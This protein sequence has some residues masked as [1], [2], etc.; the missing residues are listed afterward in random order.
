M[1]VTNYAGLDYGLGRS[2]IDLETGI[3]YGVIS[4]NTVGQAWWDWA[5]AEYGDPHCPKCGNEIKSSDDE[6]LFKCVCVADNGTAVLVHADNCPANELLDDDMP[7]WFDRQEYTCV[8]CKTCYFSEDCFPDEAQGYSFEDAEYTLTDC[9]DSDIFVLKSPYYTFA[10]FCSPY[11]PGAGNLNSPMDGENG[12]KAYALGHEW[13][14]DDKAPYRLF[15]VSDG[16][17]VM[18]ELS[19]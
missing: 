4:Q 8:N 15:R 16:L 5:E 11:V 14:E 18:P 3:R 17:E 1:S 9:L 2:N 12:A 10:Q 13:F 6:T 19:A 7:E